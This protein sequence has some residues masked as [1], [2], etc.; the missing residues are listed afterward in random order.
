MIIDNL[1]ARVF[2]QVFCNDPSPYLKP[3]HNELPYS[4]RVYA[5]D[6]A[7]REAGPKIAEKI[8]A[9]TN[10]ELLDVIADVLAGDT[11]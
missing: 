10:V 5:W 6:E 4:E 11:E 1:K 3:N 9:M 7:F 8:N 2:K